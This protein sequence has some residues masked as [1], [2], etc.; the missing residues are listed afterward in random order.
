MAETH[1]EYE[2]VC[3]NP[4]DI[5][6]DEVAM[7]QLLPILLILFTLT[8]PT[9]VWADD[10]SEEIGLPEN[11]TGSSEIT[12]DML[13]EDPGLL[14][15]EITQWLKNQKTGVS[16]TLDGLLDSKVFN[17]NVFFGGWVALFA[18]LVALFIGKFL[19]NIFRDSTIPLYEKM[20]RLTG[21]EKRPLRQHNFSP[22]GLSG[23]P[24]PFNEPAQKK[25]RVPLF[26]ELLTS[27]VNPTITPKMIENALRHQRERSDSKPRIGEI[28]V[29]LKQVSSEEVDKAL[30]FQ[31]K[32]KSK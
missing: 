27:F 30:N 2:G 6:S 25:K 31:K 1:K 20:L 10:N 11:R 3:L 15:E 13:K 7:K 9:V 18:L 26:G 24:K 23:N 5:P 12:F 16:K 22:F 29:E 4:K 32:Y 28:L 8:G 14:K 19:Y 17:T 21:R